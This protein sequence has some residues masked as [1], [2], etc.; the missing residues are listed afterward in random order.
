MNCVVLMC[1]NVEKYIKDTIR[2][3]QEIRTIGDFQNDI[4]LMYDDE[5]VYEFETNESSN[6]KNELKKNNVILKYFPKI[7]RTKYV[8]MFIE[9]PFIEGDKR[10]ITKSFQFHKFYLFNEYFKKWNKIFYIDA[11]MHI[12]KPIKKIMDLDCSYKLLAHSDTYPY[13]K[14]KLDCQFEKKSYHEIYDKLKKNFD[15]NID[16]FQTTILLF[17]TNIITTNTFDNLVELSEKYFISKTNEQGIMNLLFV[18]KLKIWKQIQIR[19]A[20]TF[21]YDFWERPKCK[22]DN[23]IMLKRIRFG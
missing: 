3:I 8:N 22:K 17:D 9:K 1:N 21:Y 23:Y 13:Y 18:S 4:V 16:F 5:L 6:F 12:F 20:D 14:N 7:N 2:N 19:D 15:L 11:G 10:E